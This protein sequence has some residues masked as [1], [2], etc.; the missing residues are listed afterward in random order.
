MKKTVVGARGKDVTEGPAHVGG[1]ER[2][3]VGVVAG[4]FEEP[5]ET[6]VFKVIVPASSKRRIARDLKV[7]TI[8]RVE[9]IDKTR[10]PILGKIK[11]TVI[12]PGLSY[13]SAKDM[14]AVGSRGKR[15]KS[16]ATWRKD[17]EILEV[18][19]LGQLVDGRVVGPLRPPERESPVYLA[20]AEDI[21]TALIV[22]QPRESSLTISL[23]VYANPETVYKPYVVIDLPMEAIW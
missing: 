21:K 18:E 2:D 14:A 5:I 3:L 20:N 4:G 13:R 17:S 8:V 7:E 6:E 22:E 12:Q 23:G 16:D 19:S 11:R 15:G 10:T 1:E 9:A